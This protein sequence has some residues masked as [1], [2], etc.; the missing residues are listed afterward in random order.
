NG[1]GH[2]Y[3]TGDPDSFPESLLYVGSFGSGDTIPPPVVS[4]IPADRATSI[5]VNTWVQGTFSEPMLSSSIT[6]STFTL[7]PSGSP[8]NVAGTVWLSGDGKTAKLAPSSNLS[9]STTYVAR[10]TTGVKDLAGNA[11]T[12]TK[13]WT[14]TTVSSDTIPPTVVS[15]IPADGATSIPVNT[16][17]QGTFSEPMLSSSI[18]PST[19]TLAPSGSPTN[20]AGTVW[21]SGDGKTAKL[22]PSSNLSPST[23]YVARLT[24]GVKD[25]AGNAMTTT[26]TW[27][28]TM[29]D[30]G[31]SSTATGSNS[32]GISG[33][34]AS[35]QTDNATGTK[36]PSFPL[37]KSVIVR[38]NPNFLNTIDGILI[39]R[40]SI[41]NQSNNNTRA[42][43][44]SQNEPSIKDKEIADLS[45]D[46]YSI[47]SIA[48]KP[49]N[50]NGTDGKRIDIVD[51][52]KHQ[53]YT[54]SK[55][56]KER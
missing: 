28:F 1:N 25:L 8:T 55:S 18:T 16:W 24:T 42:S 33:S 9:P 39:T 12:T 19:F 29:S 6:P 53:N 32:P 14:F 49:T 44:S 23:T 11:M 22:A 21:L 48:K 10:L 47:N 36:L 41:A 26:K 35:N 54:N 50:N 31:L 51:L 17:V 40:Q 5:P 27:T 46:N 4:T 3:F 30:S 34:S 56:L 52:E 38:T 37:V 20:V 15:T 45:S 13:T 7:A 43:P 2:G